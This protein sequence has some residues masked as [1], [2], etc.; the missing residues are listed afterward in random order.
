V[1]TLIS[2]RKKPDWWLCILSPPSPSRGLV[3]ASLCW[4][5]FQT[6]HASCRCNYHRW[7]T[8]TAMTNASCTY[9]QVGFMHV[10]KEHALALH[11]CHARFALLLVVA[12]M[13]HICFNHGHLDTSEWAL[14]KIQF[15]PHFACTEPCVQSCIRLC[16]SCTSWILGD[17]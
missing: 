1:S 15:E 6:R 16:Q 12:P 13:E 14:V 11:L 5:A 7:A 3:V 10:V 17:L 8:T 9:M 2:F 4:L